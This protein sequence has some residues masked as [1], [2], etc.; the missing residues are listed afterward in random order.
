MNAKGHNLFNRLARAL[1]GLQRSRL[2]KRG[3]RESLATDA[4]S[5]E[6]IR[7]H[8]DRR[9]VEIVRDAAQNIPFYRRLYREAG[10]EVASF[11]GVADMHRLPAID[12]HDLLESGDQMVRSKRSKLFTVAHT[13]GG[14]TGTVATMISRRGVS[15]LEMGCVYALWSRMGVRPN[16]HKVTLR[17]ALLDQGRKLHVREEGGRR[18]TIS[19]YHLRDDNVDEIIRLIDE[20]RPDWLHVYPSAASQLANI[21]KRTGKRLGCQIKGVLCGSE[22]VYDWQVELFAEVFGGIT[23][24]HY[25]HGE[26]AI[27]GGWCK[28]TRKFHFLP[29]HG[30]LELLDDDGKLITEPGVTGEMTATGFMDD[31]MPLIRYRTG[32]YGAWDEP[33]PCP[34]CGRAHQRMARIDGRI[35]EYLILADGTRFPL[36]NINALHGTF[37][38]LIYRFQFVQDKPGKAT[39]RFMPAVE[40]N[41]EGMAAIRNAFAYLPEIGLALEF[42][43]VEEISLTRAGKQ[44]VVVNSEYL[45]EA[46]RTG[47]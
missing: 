41:D 18:L 22:N 28:D 31:I 37:F 46:E 6:D 32:D 24:S 43:Q 38:S 20:F 25:G 2:Q 11:S 26:M 33:G 47:A 40:I 7:R 13:T 21:M 29:H 36:T 9:L 19:T 34:A 14:S 30:Y 45:P 17:G 42:R 5:A 15:C 10:V 39:L 27:L 3:F 4:W 44:R 12:R 23:Y 8:F 35:Q 16:D 1:W